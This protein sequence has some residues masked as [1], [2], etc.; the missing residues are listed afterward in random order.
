MTPCPYRICLLGIRCISA[1]RIFFDIQTEES[2]VLEVLDVQ[3]RD[4]HLLLMSRE[5][6]INRNV[7]ETKSKFLCGHD[8]RHW[9]V[10]G[11]PESAPVSSVATA[12]EALKPALV[13]DLERG[14]RGKRER[15]QGRKT[16]T[17]KRQGVSG[18]SSQPVN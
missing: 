16:P 9:F 6:V 3:P 13:R 12:M 2:V 8:E 17:F 7:P 11:V 5:L 15:R 18:S 10:A 14:L 4:R 1:C